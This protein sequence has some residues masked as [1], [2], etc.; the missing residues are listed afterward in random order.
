MQGFE[1]KWICLNLNKIVSLWY[2]F[3]VNQSP[4][5]AI[6]LILFGIIFT[7]APVF[8]EAPQ[9]RDLA[10]SQNAQFQCQV[11]G[12][13]TP[14]ITWSRN[15]TSLPVNSRQILLASG[16]LLITGLTVADEGAYTCHAE[17]RVAKFSRT[18]TLTVRSK[19]AHNSVVFHTTLSWT[20]VLYR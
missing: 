12:R 19:E 1:Q 18:T 7:A 4:C 9:N 3:S 13:P 20:D 11:S 10:V 5:I 8:L 14:I 17:N 15:D 2:S 6:E 16:D